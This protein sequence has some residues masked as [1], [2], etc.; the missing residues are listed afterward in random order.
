M[1]IVIDPGAGFCFGV[2]R[3]INIAEEFLLTHEPLGCLGEIVHNPAENQR[4]NKAGLEIITIDQIDKVKLPKIMI[5][6]HG[7]P[8]GTYDLFKFKKQ[9]YID[10]TCPIVIH[11]QKKIRAAWNEIKELK[12]QIVIF[13]KKNHPEVIGLNGQTGNNALIVE[14]TIDLEQI[15]FSRPIRLFAQ[16]TSDSHL[17][18]ELKN[19]I[20]K[21]IAQ[22]DNID[23]QVFNSVCKHVSGR[24][25][26]L[27][28]FARQHDVIIFVAGRNS[29]NGKFLFSICKMENSRSYLISQPEQIDLQWFA[30]CQTVGISGATSTPDWQLKSVAEA[31]S[32]L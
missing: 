29:S 10:A 14:S 20:Q 18:V 27:K 30:G 19:T 9:E 11:L 24:V 21:Q 12:G 23:F 26:E 22:F 17:F 2:R 15:D 13:G 31:I 25:E 4:L 16:T 1:N 8:P 7:E 28:K 6:S 32:S 3:A 5:R